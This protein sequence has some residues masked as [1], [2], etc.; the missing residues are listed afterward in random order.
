VAL[1]NRV[2]VWWLSIGIGCAAARAVS[3]FAYLSHGAVAVA[4]LI[5]MA[6]TATFVTVAAV[7]AL[8]ALFP[9]RRRPAQR[10]QH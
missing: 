1:V 5:A 8:D 6:A 3:A 7:T 10:S 9:A 2:L 4:W